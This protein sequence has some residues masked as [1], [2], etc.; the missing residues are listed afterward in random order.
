VGL[1]SRFDNAR[2]CLSICS[3]DTHVDHGVFD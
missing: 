2:K 1:T 3:T